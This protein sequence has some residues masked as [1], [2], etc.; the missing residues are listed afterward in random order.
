MPAELGMKTRQR[1]DR[2]M[3]PVH[4]LT[5]RGSRTPNFCRGAKRTGAGRARCHAGGGG[6]GGGVK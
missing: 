6:G 3:G 5:A 2:G 1:L 4:P